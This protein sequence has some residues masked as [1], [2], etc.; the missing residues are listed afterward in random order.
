MEEMYKYSITVELSAG[1][2]KK[3]APTEEKEI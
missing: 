3:E 1:N 2:L